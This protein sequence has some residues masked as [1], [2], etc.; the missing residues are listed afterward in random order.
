MQASSG[1]I[2]VIQ[3]LLIVAALVTGFI[4]LGLGSDFLANPGDIMFLLNGIG[5]IGLTGLFVLPIARVRPYH[6]TVRWVLVG[7][8]LLTIVL[9]V[10]INGKLDVVG[11]VAKLSELLIIVVLLIDRARK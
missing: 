10:F 9:W 6:E 3:V 8:A 11:I 7:Y 2:G 5:F 1:K 4:H